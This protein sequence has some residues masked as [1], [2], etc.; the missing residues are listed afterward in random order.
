MKN[1]FLKC[2]FWL[3]GLFNIGLMLTNLYYLSNF[4]PRYENPSFDYLGVIVGIL[5]FLVAILA[6]LLGYNI[7]SLDKKIDECIEKKQE[8]LK[9]NLLNII[10]DTKAQLYYSASLINRESHQIQLEFHNLLLAA[11]ELLNSS[12][13]SN[14]E[15]QMIEDRLIEI[16]DCCR[17][18]EKEYYIHINE[19]Q[20]SFYIEIAKKMPNGRSHKILQYLI[21]KK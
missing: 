6:I 11:E 12:I 17:K 7:F 18:K 21:E 8:E 3:I 10:S 15:Y 4:Y 9:V 20:L 5:S 1:Y 14:E 19:P 13:K 2:S 16:I